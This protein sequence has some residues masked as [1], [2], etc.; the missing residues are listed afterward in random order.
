MS[1]AALVLFLPLVFGCTKKDSAP[2][3]GTGTTTMNIAGKWNV[4][5]KPQNQDTIL[6]YFILDATNTTKGWKIT[7]PNR[8]PMDSRVVHM[9]ND[10]VVVENG[11]YSSA[12]FPGVKVRTH[13]MYRVEGD[14]LR[15]YTIAHYERSGPDSVLFL[16]TTG[17]RQ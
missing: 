10:S 15:G 17:V 16:V 11:P 1:R 14:T 8:Q 5:V 7:L 4:S 9:D 13:T 2:A 6:I 3:T 12:L